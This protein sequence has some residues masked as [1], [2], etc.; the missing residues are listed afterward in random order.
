MV[1]LIELGNRSLLR[2]LTYFLRNPSASL[3]YTQ[4]RKKIKIAKATLTFHLKFLVKA[5]IVT[6]QAIGLN[7]IYRLDMNN[8]VV[9]QLKVID[10]LLLLELLKEAAKKYGVEIYLYG[11]ASR[12]EDLEGSDIDLLV[13]GGVVKEKIFPEIRSLERG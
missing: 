13:I 3:S 10:S 7:K 8:K 5:R 9:R 1:Q 11:S 12:G 2:I 6:L 4:L